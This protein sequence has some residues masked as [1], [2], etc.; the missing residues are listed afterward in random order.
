MFGETSKVELDL[1]PFALIVVV[2]TVFVVPSTL[3]KKSLSVVSVQSV[4]EML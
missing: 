3:L 4:A 1:A 2:S